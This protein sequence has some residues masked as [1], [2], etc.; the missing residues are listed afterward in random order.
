MLNVN[1]NDMNKYLNPNKLKLL[2]KGV[3]SVKSRVLNLKDKY[4]FLTKDIIFDQ[5]IKE[6]LDYHKV[7]R[8]NTEFIELPDEVENKDKKVMDLYNLYNSWEWKFGECPEFTDSLNYKFSWGLVDLSLFVEKGRIIN[9]IVYSDCLNIE[10]I[11]FINENLKN[12]ESLSLTY[13]EEG[14]IQLMALLK[15]KLNSLINN[16]S[17]HNNVWGQ[18]LN[19]MEIELKKLI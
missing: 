15:S 19:E 5:L 11:D 17:L 9:A 4:P 6:F 2:S 1:T 14:F 3:D 8:E 16:N 13:N 12:I 10:F 18:Y 7:E